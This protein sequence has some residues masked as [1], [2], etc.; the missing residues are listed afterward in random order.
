MIQSENS[1]GYGIARVRAIVARFDTP[2]EAVAY[3]EARDVANLGN[4]ELYGRAVAY[5]RAGNHFEALKILGDLLEDDQ[6]VIAYHIA[7]GQT[8][9]ALDQYS[10]ALRVFERAVELFPRNVPLVV[11]Y[12]ERLLELGQPKK[13]HAMLLDLL[14]NVPPTPDQVRLIARAASLAGE[15]AEA[16]YYLAEYRLMIGDLAGGIGYLQQ[17]LRL[18]ELQEI[19]RARFEARIDFIR[20]FMTEEQLKRMQSSRPVGVA[21]T[22]W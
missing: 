18:P 15:D 13:A 12:G 3:F 9:V 1:T 22:G 4:I 21:R 7:L 2:E 17:A 11:E 8:L 19:Q 10:D 14:N 5:Q 16:Y 20:E 6:A